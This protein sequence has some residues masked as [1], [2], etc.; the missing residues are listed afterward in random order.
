MQRKMQNIPFS[1]KALIFNPPL[2][3][4]DEDPS[5][6][7]KKAHTSKFCWNHAPLEQIEEKKSD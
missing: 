1:Q 6:S 7:E 4:A 2:T 3:E 5:A